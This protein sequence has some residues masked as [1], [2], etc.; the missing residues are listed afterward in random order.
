MAITASL[1]KE[2]RERTGAGMME[3]KKA[4]VET[5]G[6]ID[7]AIEQMRKSGQAKAAKKAGR[8]AAEGVIVTSFS[9]DCSEAAMLEVNC[10]TDFVGKD[11]NFTSFAKAV[12]ERVL[13]G[14]ADDVAALMEQPLHEGEETTVNQAREALISKLGENMNVRRFTRIR[15]GSGKLTSYRHGVRIGVVIELEGGDE[16]LGKDLAMHIAATNPICLSADQMPQDLLDKE[17]DIVT[18]QAKE[19]GKPDEIIAKMVDGRMRKYLAENTLLG[20]AFV[21][22]PDMTV[23]KLLKSKSASIAQ[24]SRFEVGEGIEKKQ[25]NFAEEVMA[26]AKM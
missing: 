14:G 22:D 1:V 20:Q 18:A 11:E 3:C 4:L 2:L 26:Q 13:A 24:Y 10:E 9:E 6:D 12:A 7:A 5:D 17:R 16:E 19:S 8:I 21:K 23:E 25:E 15:A